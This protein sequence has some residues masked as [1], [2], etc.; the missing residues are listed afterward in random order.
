MT[1]VRDR[2]EVFSSEAPCGYKLPNYDEMNIEVTR[3]LLSENT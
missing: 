1:G 3:K 2:G